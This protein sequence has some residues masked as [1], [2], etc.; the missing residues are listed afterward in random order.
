M[1]TSHIQK[2]HKHDHTLSQNP[3]KNF[4]TLVKSHDPTSTSQKY[5]WYG[6]PINSLTRK[7]KVT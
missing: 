5:T 6:A 3:N 7:I 2:Y 1:T 4:T